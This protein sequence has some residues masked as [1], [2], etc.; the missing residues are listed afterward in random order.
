MRANP[1]KDKVEVLPLAE[2]DA[3]AIADLAG[4]IWRQHYPD[5]ITMEQINYMLA[6]R[7]SPAD[8]RAQLE[9]EEIWW[10]KL[11]VNG[12]LAGFSNYF[13]T[14]NPGE[15]KLDKLYVH[16]E[17][18]RKGCGGRLLE[19]ACQVASERH[20][21]HL[22]LCV[23]KRNAK[24]IAAYRKHGFAVSDSVVTDIG[25]GFVMDDYLMTKPL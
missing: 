7:Y 24:A 11:L 22:I 16:Q 9:N 8:I 1:I 21:A 4:V 14:K 19:R 18:Q 23:N 2:K 10:D 12:E 20:C 15:M 3:E 13:L 5:I 25:R 17:H 6:R